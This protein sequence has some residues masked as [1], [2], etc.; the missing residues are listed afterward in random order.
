MRMI[1]LLNLE[2][3]KKYFKITI[4]YNLTLYIYLY[5]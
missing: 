3:R 2:T 4:Q 1:A 5:A